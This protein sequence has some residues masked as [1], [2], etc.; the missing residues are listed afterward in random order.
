MAQVK[1]RGGDGEERKETLADKPGILKTAH[2]VC[3]VWVRAPTFDAVIS[4]HNWPIKCLP[5]RR[6]EM[7]FRGRV[8]E[9]KII[10]FCTLE[11]VEGVDGEISINPNDQCRLCTFVFLIRLK[12]R[13]A[14]VKFWSFISFFL[15]SLPLFIF[16]LSFHFSRGQNR[17]SPSSV[18]LCSE[19]KRKRLL[20]RQKFK[21]T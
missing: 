5:F 9:T 11:R 19:T 16:W 21:T 1:E 3:H 10:F 2:L 8:C 18:F 20:R 4:C 12:R 15:L 14:R 17:K 7:N 6:A 13:T